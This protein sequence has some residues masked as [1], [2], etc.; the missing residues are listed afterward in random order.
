MGV[1]DARRRTHRR[2][3]ARDAAHERRGRARPL[4]SSP[5]SVTAEGFFYVRAGIEA[6]IARGLAYAPYA[7][8]VWM[9]DLARPTSDEAREFAEAIHAEF[10]GKLL[11]YNCSPSFNW[12]QHLDDDDDRAVPARARRDG[13]QVPVHH[14]RR[15]P[16]AQRVDV[17]ARARVRGRGDAAPTCGCRSASSRSRTTATRRRSTSARSA[18]AGSTRSPR[19]SPA[20]ESTL[21]LKG[22]T[23]EAQFSGNG[24]AAH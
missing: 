9:R 12:R 24:V 2:R 16:R 3:L 17:R 14:P 8:L 21:A 10:P 7:D 13:L 15:L 22:S 20:A 1:P 23:E 4:R 18:P 6:A 5:A 11:A 19:R